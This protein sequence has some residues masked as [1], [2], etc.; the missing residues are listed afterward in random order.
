MMKT[1]D[2]AIGTAATAIPLWLHYFE[3]FGE[4]FIVGGGI[5]LIIIR[6]ALAIREWMRGRKP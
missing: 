5:I 6:V 1:A 3:N 4:A 2:V